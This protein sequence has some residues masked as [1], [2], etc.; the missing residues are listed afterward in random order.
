L[1]IGSALSGN[2]SAVFILREVV[3]M[4]RRGG[5]FLR[6]QQ[7]RKTMLWILIGIKSNLEKRPTV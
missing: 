6:K 3:C 1:G 7:V 2:G 4:Q 5:M